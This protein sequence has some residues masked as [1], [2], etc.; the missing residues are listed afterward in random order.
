MGRPPHRFRAQILGFAIAILATGAA[1][2]VRL[3]LDQRL[4]DRALFLLF[5]PAVAL[6]AAV[7]GF[8]PA[9]LATG[10]ALL[11]LYG[12]IGPAL[13]SDYTNAVSTIAFAVIG[14]GAA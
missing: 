3:G 14:L 1:L 6:S 4:Q 8:A 9:L 5:V 2:A 10:L 12:I 7:G 13:L 11:V